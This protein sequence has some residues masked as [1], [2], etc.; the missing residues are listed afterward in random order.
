MFCNSCGAPNPDD[1]AFCSGCG[2][3]VVRPLTAAPPPTDRPEP[4][5]L[6]NAT[7]AP[8]R[9]AATITPIVAPAAAAEAPP[10]AL[11][12]TKK[13][14][15]VRWGWIVFACIVL[16]IFLY[17]L[18]SGSGIC[19]TARDQ[20]V[21]QV[22]PAVEILAARYPLQ[23][24]LLRSM[25]NDKGMVDSIAQEYVRASIQENQQEPGRLSCYLSYYVVMLYTDRVRTSIAD[26]MET[27][28]QLK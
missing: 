28:L 6:P 19:D 8:R 13:K 7:G 3:P 9:D 20:V 25:F 4:A 24:G 12:R 10:A 27:R 2:K 11:A 14:R 5:P 17:P 21:Q 18:R 26:W 22:P 23:I 16:L 15:G 1:A